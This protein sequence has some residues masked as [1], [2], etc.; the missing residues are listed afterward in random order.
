MER[1]VALLFVDWRS[2]ATFG[3]AHLPQD[4]VYVSRLFAEIVANAVHAAGG[5]D[6]ESSDGGAMAVFGL[7]EALPR[8]VSRSACRGQ[9]HRARATRS[10]APP[11]RRISCRGRLCVVLAR[12]TRRRC[13]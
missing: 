11:A 2:R 7:T 13:F 9:Q 10:R 5:A 4:V 3:T 6:G 8:R 1:D 12:R